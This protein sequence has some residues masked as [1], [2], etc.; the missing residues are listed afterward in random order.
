MQQDTTPDHAG[1]FKIF[2]LLR[3]SNQASQTIEKIARADAQGLDDAVAQHLRDTAAHSLR[4]R[5]LT[6]EPA[7]RPRGKPERLRRLLAA[8][9]PAH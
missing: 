7:P 8:L 6:P 1:R 4:R 3:Q 9:R 5:E 2:E